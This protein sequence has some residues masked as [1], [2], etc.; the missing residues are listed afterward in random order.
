M[1]QKILTSKC[2]MAFQIAFAILTCYW[3]IVDAPNTDVAIVNYLPL[4]IIRI[5]SF[6]FFLLETIANVVVY[7]LVKE[8]TSYLR[9]SKFNIIKLLILI[10]NLLELTPLMLNSTF[11]HVSKLKAYRSLTLV[12]LR[13]KTNW[14]MK[15]L[16][17]SLYQLLP[18]LLK[19][20]MAS[21]LVLL[22]FALIFTKVYKSQD[23]YCDNAFDISR[24]QTAKDCME[25]GGDWVMYRINYSNIYHSMVAMFMMSSMEG[26]IG[27]MAEAMNFSDPGKAPSYNHNEHIQ[28][29]FVAFFFLGN[30]VIMNSFIGMTLYNFKQIKERET[31]EKEMTEM[32]KLWLRI[33][34]QIIQ[35]QPLPKEKAPEN[36]LR[37]KFYWL[38]TS[39]GYQILK[40]TLF[41]SYL[42]FCS[43]YRSNLPTQEYNLLDTINRTFMVGVLVQY[44][45]ELVAF[46]CRRHNRKDFI[47]ETIACVY[48]FSFFYYKARLN[49]LN[50]GDTANR[51]L[52]G[53][54]IFFQIFRYLKRNSH[55]I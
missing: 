31:G 48:I 6:G 12:E 18:K 46:G 2:F 40:I 45:L 26:W 23:Y 52:S 27:M 53:V 17:R 41:A 51:A 10:L 38:C 19:L 37:E 22:F 43:F 28:V 5:T 47:F 32:E 1:L 3:L 44:L 42:V 39:R 14:E 35:Q 36:C 25:W 15:I 13:Y 33:K 29:F 49:I 30:M 34:V 55:L 21:L 50:S 7:G 4:K 20:L 24:V 8:E 11:R 54:A 16:I 9:R